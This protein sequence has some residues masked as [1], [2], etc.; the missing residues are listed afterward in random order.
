MADDAAAEDGVLPRELAGWDRKERTS[1]VTTYAAVPVQV[2]MTEETGDNRYLTRRFA[3]RITSGEL[4]SKLRVLGRNRREV[5]DK[6]RDVV[7]GGLLALIRRHR[8]TQVAGARQDG[9]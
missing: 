3:A 7:L 5:A 8:G 1:G 6:V 2:R 4:G 9:G